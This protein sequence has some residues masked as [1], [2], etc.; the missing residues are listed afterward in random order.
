MKIAATFQNGRTISGHAGKVNKFVVFTIENKEIVERVE[1]N[2]DKDQAFHNILHD[3]VQP[4]PEHPLLH[5]SALM[6]HN[7]A[8]GFFNKM[9]MNNIEAINVV[10]LDPDLAIKQLLEGKLEIIP[11][12]EGHSCGCGGN[13]SH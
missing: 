5:I 11:V 3:G 8:A 9:R 6:G 12:D 2:L 10:E 7:M 1:L 4:V 13:H